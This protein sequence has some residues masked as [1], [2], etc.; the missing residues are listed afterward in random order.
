MPKSYSKDDI[1]DILYNAVGRSSEV[2]TQSA[3][4]LQL[5]GG[6]NKAG[7]FKVAGNSGYSLGIFQYDF[8]A[9]SSVKNGASNVTEIN[10]L[11]DSYNAWAA[12]NGQAALR[13][14]ER[15]QL[16]NDLTSRGETLEG[17]REHPSKDYMAPGDLLRAKI[18][19][20]LT[21]DAG[22]QFVNRLDSSVLN[23]SPG[24]PGLLP[25]A[26][27]VAAS[28]TVQN[29]SHQDGE[30]A[31]AALSK[32]FNQNEKLAGEILD[33]LHGQSMDFEQFDAYISAKVDHS[34]LSASSKHALSSGVAAT[35][36]GMK[37]IDDI[38]NS[39]ALG[40]LWSASV[41]RD[42]SLESNFS[43]M[44]AQQL[45]DAMLRNPAAGERILAAIDSGKGALISTSKASAKETYIAGVAADG[46]LFTMDEQ[47]KGR[48]YVNGDW[49]S[50]TNGGGL[51]ERNRSG[52]WEIASHGAADHL[53]AVSNSPAATTVND[54]IL[55]EVEAGS[56]GY[57]Q[58][59]AEVAGD[60]EALTVNQANI[61]PLRF[62]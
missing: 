42:P 55:A 57:L 16:T 3:F 30:Y 31:I 25:F 33:G 37:L 45:F 1:L 5:A 18:D 54:R 23:T 13:P 7:E 50:F 53:A 19:R 14:D 20:F 44:P 48:R 61:R 29:M 39:P 36:H 35:V 56:I 34:K 15:A 27:R 60:T 58:L 22:L 12:E 4:S 38:R 8:G 24:Y 62:N 59:A 28:Q 43:K 26:E 6:Y 32:V 17:N 41:S 9:R 40:P 46:T 52:R 21:S 47:G 2:G 10:S 49:T 11:I 51:T